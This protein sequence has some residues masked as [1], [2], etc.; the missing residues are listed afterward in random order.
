MKKLLPLILCL[1]LCWIN[2]NSIQKIT[3]LPIDSMKAIVESYETLNKTLNDTY[4][5]PWPN[6]SNE[7]RVQ[8]KQGLQNIQARL[9]KID[10]TT[11]TKVS[12]IDYDLL[13]LVLNNR[14]YLSEF[15]AHLFPLNS[16]GGFLTGIVYSTQNQKLSNEEAFIKFQEKL[17]ILPTYFI[18]TPNIKPVSGNI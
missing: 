15:D 14:L 1:S 13:S 18:L 7:K 2:C 4:A 8:E 5:S 9:N 11:L 10:K 6:I 3:K 16:E 17:N 12:K